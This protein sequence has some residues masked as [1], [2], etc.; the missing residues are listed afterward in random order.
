MTAHLA[1]SVDAAPFAARATIVTS[2]GATRCARPRAEAKVDA[3]PRALRR[4]M[5]EERRVAAGRPRTR[6]I[7]AAPQFV[8]DRTGA[9]DRRVGGLE[10]FDERTGALRLYAQVWIVLKTA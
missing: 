4:Q 6:R 7:D 3:G 2:P 1:R 5:L 9:R 8:G 10:A